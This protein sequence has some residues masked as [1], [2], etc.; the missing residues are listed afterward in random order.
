MVGEIAEN[1]T[2][3]DQYGNIC[4]DVILITVANS[5][6]IPITIELIGYLNRGTAFVV[7]P[8][9]R[10]FN[11][12]PIKIESSDKASVWT[13]NPGKISR[14]LRIDDCLFVSDSLGNMY[15]SKINIFKIVYRYFWRKLKLKESN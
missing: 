7:N 4:D 11:T 15:Y 1:F 10:L 2:L 5:G 8:D 6:Y 13:K 3:K 14:I 12:L 9:P